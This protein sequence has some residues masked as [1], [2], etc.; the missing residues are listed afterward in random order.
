[1]ADLAKVEKLTFTVLFFLT[2]SFS[3]ESVA[4]IPRFQYPNSMPVSY[5]HLDVYKRQQCIRRVREECKVGNE[6]VPGADLE[7][8]TGLC[9]AVTHGILLHS[10]ES[11]VLVR[12][13]IGD[14]YKRQIL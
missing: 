1:M 11:C 2:A 13:G 6:L 7:V 10:H 14:V 3:S 12:L 5:T 4:G 8:V 9:L